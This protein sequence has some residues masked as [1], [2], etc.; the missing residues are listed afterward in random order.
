[1]AQEAAAFFFFCKSICL[2]TFCL[3]GK[4]VSAFQ[5]RRPPWVRL[6]VCVQSMAVCVCWWYS[7]EHSCLPKHGSVCVCVCVCTHSLT[8]L[9]TRCVVSL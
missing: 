8:H 5:S 6:A 3:K 2:S 4:N 1:M 7:G 9:P